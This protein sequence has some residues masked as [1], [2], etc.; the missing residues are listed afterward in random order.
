MSNRANRKALI[1]PTN[2]VEGYLLDLVISC[3][4][5]TLDWPTLL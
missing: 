3:H 5:L 4:S 2:G 1:L